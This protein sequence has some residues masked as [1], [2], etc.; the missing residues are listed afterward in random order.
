MPPGVKYYDKALGLALV[1]GIFLL[2]VGTWVIFA[3]SML[4]Y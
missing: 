2:T 1:A 4:S 3:K